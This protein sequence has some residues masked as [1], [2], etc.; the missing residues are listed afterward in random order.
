MS[1]EDLF[2]PLVDI[3]PIHWCLDNYSYILQTTNFLKAFFNTFIYALLVAVLTTVSTSMIGY[4]FSKFKFKGV[5]LLTLIVIVSMMMPLQT[6]SIP[7]YLNFRFFDILDILKLF[8]F[9]Q[10]NLLDTVAPT[11]IMSITG[12]GFR[13]GIFIIL[14]RQYFNGVPNEV[15]EAAYVDGAGPYRTF[16]SII[17]PMA[18]SMLVVVFALSFAW[19]WTDTFYSS[20]LYGNVEL[21]PNLVSLLSQVT[22][23][24]ASYYLDYVR[25]DTAAIMA[26]SPLILFYCFLQ[27]QIIQGIERSGLVG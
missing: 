25:A 17:I 14:M 16:I 11:T 4:G 21:L 27:K 3:I 19:Q 10:I 22:L 18:K 15:L 9:K 20:L 23:E 8:G 24:N 5:K 2:D 1:S 6:L 26:I 13:A 7:I 12:F